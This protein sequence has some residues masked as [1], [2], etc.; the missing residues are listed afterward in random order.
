MEVSRALGVPSPYIWHGEN[1]QNSI[2][3]SV[4][5][6]TFPIPRERTASEIGAIV[7]QEHVL[8]EA[9]NLVPQRCAA[10]LPKLFGQH[11]HSGVGNSS[12]MPC[13][14]RDTTLPSILRHGKLESVTL[15]C[16]RRVG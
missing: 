4:R 11:E 12:S 10:R 15:R 1:P 3:T 14:R 16:Q 2:R 5:T 7:E 8:A 6:V 13:K 9:C